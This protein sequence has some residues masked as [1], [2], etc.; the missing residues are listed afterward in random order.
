MRWIDSIKKA[1]AIGEFTDEDYVAASGW[2]TCCV[3]EA[4]TPLK[5]SWSSMSLAENSH[6][7]MLGMR[8]MDEVKENQ[9]EAAM[10]TYK[11]I[12]DESARLGS[13]LD[14]H[15]SRSEGESD[16]SQSVTRGSDSR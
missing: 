5:C 4:K 10:L 9:P 11:E 1:L 6:L 15:S 7:Y 3:G 2:A 13:V 12:Q 14:E 16:L 8:F